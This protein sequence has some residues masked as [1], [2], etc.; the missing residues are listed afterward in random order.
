MET[1]I[2][3][4]QSNNNTDVI[5][6][7]IFNVTLDQ[8]LKLNKNDTLGL[9]SCYIDTISES[10][11]KIVIP[12]EFEDIT[13]TFGLYLQDQP[14]TI[15]K[16]GKA[17]TYFKT[18]ADGP[19]NSLVARPNGDNYIL[20]SK[21]PTSKHATPST[22]MYEYKGLSMKDFEGTHTIRDKTLKGFLQYKDSTGNI[23]SF[24]YEL[25]A[26]TWRKIA[27]ENPNTETY[28]FNENSDW[29]IAP[30]LPLIC[31][32][33]AWGPGK[34]VRINP[35]NV[36]SE[37][38][39][40]DNFNHGE[41]IFVEMLTGNEIS[42][43]NIYNPWLFDVTIHIPAD[44]YQP[45][46]LT[47]MLTKEL[48]RALSSDNTIPYDDISKNM[49]LQSLTQIRTRGETKNASP[50]VP[51]NPFW[52]SEDGLDAIQYT[53]TGQTNNYLFG[54]SAFEIGF[55][56]ESNLASI[57]SMHSD[58]YSG[59]NP[60]I[61]PFQQNN[62][63]FVINKMGGMFLTDC[64]YSDLLIKS[65]NLP[66]SIFTL[67]TGSTTVP[68]GALTEST[69]F[70]FNLQDGIN[71]TGMSI[72]N[73]AFIT[74]G[75]NSANGAK[76]Y[77]IAPVYASDGADYTTVKGIVSTQVNNI[78]GLAP[79]GINP[80]EDDDSTPYYQ[81]EID[82]NFSLNKVSNAKESKQIMAVVNK[83]YS[84][85]SFTIGDS[86]M[87]SLY[88]HDSDE[89]M[90]LKDFSVRILDPDGDEIDPNIIQSNN[91]IF[92]SLMRNNPQL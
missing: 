86:S 71:V 43:A 66:S 42:T 91:V 44:S 72:F 82:S 37:G 62:K 64:T 90:L 17:K 15:E 26:K 89:P 50:I 65:L 7:G 92:L 24:N 2:E 41:F 13:F 79:I 10:E 1:I 38:T 12:T 5:Q 27:K 29:Q 88:I 32:Y 85:N 52:I 34:P 18:D 40:Y 33:N 57:D 59:N 78:L 45:L 83:Y 75:S 31:D 47:Q 54:C 74:K 25:E 23:R 55:D 87:S 20:C 60:C 21:D 6:N 61:V 8:P 49:L 14:T 56:I 80:N 53:G 68:I 77:D 35:N 4:K 69:F 46:K 51:G 67:S 58:I 63:Q 19:V 3:L 28:T 76:T 48:N 11:G 84:V 16:A 81:I 30:N 73:D 9:K 70:T 39:G 36:N 22:T